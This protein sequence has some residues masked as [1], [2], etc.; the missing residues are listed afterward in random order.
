MAVASLMTAR[1][2]H[3]PIRSP[4]PEDRIPVEVG[5][6]VR[7]KDSRAALEPARGSPQRSSTRSSSSEYEED[8]FTEQYTRP[9]HAVHDC[10]TPGADAPSQPGREVT[11]EHRRTTAG[12]LEMDLG[13]LDQLFD[14]SGRTSLP[15]MN[16]HVPSRASMT[17]FREFAASTVAAAAQ[18]AAASAAAAVASGTVHSQNELGQAGAIKSSPKGAR[19]PSSELQNQ[20]KPTDGEAHQAPR[21][22]GPDE[23]SVSDSVLDSFSWFSDASRRSLPDAEFEDAH[24]GRA[25]GRKANSTTELCRAGTPH[26]PDAPG[27]SEPEFDSDSSSS[28]DADS[29]SDAGTGSSTTSSDSEDDG[30]ELARRRQS[31]PMPYALGRALTVPNH[32]A[33]PPPR[34]RR[35]NT[36]TNL[37][38]RP[39]VPVS[40]ATSAN[41][42]EQYLPQDPAPHVLPHLEPEPPQ[43]F[44]R[45]TVEY[46]PD[47]LSC[48]PPTPRTPSQAHYHTPAGGARSHAPLSPAS[49]RCSEGS[50]VFH[51]R[52]SNVQPRAEQADE[53]GLVPSYTPCMP[54]YSRPTPSSSVARKYGGGSSNSPI[55]S[56]PFSLGSARDPVN[57]GFLL[58]R[59]VSPER[60]RKGLRKW[61]SWFRRGSAKDEPLPNSSSSSFVSYD[62]GPVISGPLDVFQYHNPP[63]HLT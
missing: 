37:H 13:V 6:R 34:R 48:A 50:F 63:F 1:P 27:P 2:Q 3:R 38:G 17:W 61:F 56:E 20:S 57:P 9:L 8:L 23:D 10:S 41:A 14:G 30:M 42:C 4:R 53:L 39:R 31:S 25:R 33:A 43:A 5:K 26:A 60:P 21:S 51:P 29:G 35:S 18:A 47:V 16:G 11:Q 58:K 36:S 40:P 7:F 55:I 49:T 24:S 28:D 44:A 59:S 46:S 45:A 54:P 32:G 19:Q 15:A 62:N 52:G 22:A 12:A